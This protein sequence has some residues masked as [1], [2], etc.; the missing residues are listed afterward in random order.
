MRVAWFDA[1]D[2]HKEY[3]DSGH[4]IDFFSESASL[5]DLDSSYDAITVFVDSEVT[6]EMIEKVQ[7]DRV[8]C[9]SSGYDNVDLEAAEENNVKVFNVPDYG[10]ETVAEYTM[11]LLLN[12]ARRLEEDIGKNPNTDS[13]IQGFELKGKPLGVIGAGRIGREV[14]KRAKAFDMKVIA[15][16][17]FPDEEAAREIGYTYESLDKVLSTADFISVN[18]PL[19]DSTKHLLSEREFEQMDDVVLV[20]T[21]RGAVIDSDALADA[22]RNGSVRDAAL[23]VVEEGAFKELSSFENVIF[24]PH[25]AYNTR[26]A[27]EMIVDRSLKNL[28]KESGDL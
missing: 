22:L 25:N 4:E 11:A 3:I 13:G 17:P 15:Y 12:A 24:T 21:G 28:E 1:E 20:N 23:D 9:R 6:G 7:P 5:S 26:E 18:C 10:S 8:V 2:W 14:I 16:D 19:N 27:E